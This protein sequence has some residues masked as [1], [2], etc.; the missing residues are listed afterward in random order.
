MGRGFRRRPGRSAM[1]T[2]AV[3]VA[4]ALLVSLQSLAAGFLAAQTSEIRERT[5][6]VLLQ[7][8][9]TRGDVT[10]TGLRAAGI[11]DAHRV[12]REVAALDG[13]EGAS[14]T[15][16]AVVFGRA[17]PEANATSILAQGVVPAE[18]AAGL[19]DAQKA[20]F[21][22]WFTTG[23]DD[24][25]AEAVVNKALAERHGVG[26]G[27]DL[28]LAPSPT[29]PPRAFR[30][31][32]VF[33]SPFTGTGVLGGTHIAFLKLTALQHLTGVAERDAATRIAIRLA[34]EARADPD[35]TARVVDRLK[36]DHPGFQVLTKQDE[37]R[38]ARERAAISAGFYT[39]VAWVSLVVSALFVASVM[40]MEVQ[41]RRRDL[42]VLRAIGWGRGS[43]FRLVAADALLFVAI[44]TALGIALGY[45]ASEALGRYFQEGYGLDVSF[46]SFTPQLALASAA[47]SLL[48]GVLAA[49][50]PAWKA[51]RVDA[52]TI[53]RTA[54]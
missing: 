25:R 44:G 32:G 41:E 22:G 20:K 47:Q 14:P 30:V 7:P 43:V 3:A 4:V 17:T 54:R 42:G 10:E 16:E 33:E 21:D 53:L 45:F 13:V 23:G 37:L 5:V 40:I 6:D 11:Q 27:D 15:L 52:L 31:V 48:V 9:A 46:T 50:Y 36:A 19:S 8:V 34:P 26:K 35:A 1:M 51:S 28:L 29:D 49:L 39:A 2:A 24:D 12:A 18:H 38:D